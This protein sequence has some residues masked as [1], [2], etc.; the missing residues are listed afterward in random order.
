MRRAALWVAVAAAAAAMVTTSSGA[1]TTY[2][3]GFDLSWPQCSGSA[4]RHMPAHTP[5]YLILGLTHGRGH[6]ANPCLASQSAWA[7]QRGV[8]VG[9]YLVPSYPTARQRAAADLGLY[10]ACHGDAT[11]RLRNDGARQAADALAVL[12][13]NGVPAPMVW[14]DVEFRHVQ[15]WSHSHAGNVHVLQGVLRG[16]TAAGVPYGVYTTSYMWRSITG[17]WRVDTPNWLPGGSGNP[18]DAKRMC[19]A[20]ATGGPT[21]VVQYT[22]S[23]DEDLTCPVMD[24]TPGH[25]GPLWRYRDTVL[26]LGSSGP[27][28]RA[29]QKAL[30]K[31]GVSGTYDAATFYAVVEFQQ[32]NGLPVNG[33]VDKDD[34][35][36]LGALKT[37]GGHPFLLSRMARAR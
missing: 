17:G 24:A 20:T 16:L 9:A 21:W 29:L 7:Q 36:A 12:H 23:L 27:A 26:R 6:T 30:R 33:Q 34:W 19:R 2:T 15:P 8:P 5:A 25:P 32:A 1:S 31:V 4:A 22:R 18:A 37:Y 35:V 13:D 28:V 11:C 3:H 10:G 14:V